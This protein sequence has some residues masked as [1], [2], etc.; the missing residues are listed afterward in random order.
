MAGEAQSRAVQTGAILTRIA[1]QARPLSSQEQVWM[2]LAARELAAA[3]VDFTVNGAPAASPTVTLTDNDPAPVAIANTGDDSFITLTTTGLPLGNAPSGGTGYA[4]TRSYVS[5]TGEPV[6]LSSVKV[7]ARMAVVLEITPFAEGAARLMVNDPLPAGFEIDNPSLI[8]S[9]QP[10]LASLGLLDE[11]TQAEYRQ[12]RF[13][14]A[15]DRSDNQPFRLGYIVRAVS[16]GA[17]HHPAATVE[18]MYRPAY[19]GR[20]DAGRLVIAP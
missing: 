14:A 2:A 1:A 3:P 8:G 15:V 10:A 19:S 11:V 12:D 4:I 9:A 6:D 18:D 20:S 17:F 5:M 16:A 13:L 7:G